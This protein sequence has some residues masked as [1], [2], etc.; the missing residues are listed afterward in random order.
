M[1]I[2]NSRFH[3]VW[4]KET[5]NGYTKLNLGDS[6]KKQDG[7][8][9]NFTWYGCTLVHTAKT[10]PVEEGDTITILSAEVVKNKVNDKEYTNVTIFDFEVTKQGKKADTPFDETNNFEQIEDDLEGLPF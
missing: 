9:D 5:Q 6:K 2:A 10:K 3:R 4:K 8:Y 7:T 1:N